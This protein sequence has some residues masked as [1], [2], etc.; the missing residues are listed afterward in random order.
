M[1]SG[2]NIISQAFR[3]VLSCW[4]YFFGIVLFLFILD[5]VNMLYDIDNSITVAKAFAEAGVVFYVCLSFLGLDVSSKENGKK[6]MGFSLRFLFLLYVPVIVAS[7][8][9]VALA[10]STLQ[11]AQPGTGYFMGLTMLCVGGVYFFAMFLFGTVFP[12]R[13]FGVRPEIGAAVGRAFRQAGY[14]IPRLLLGVWGLSALSFVILILAENLGIG[15]DPV[16]SAGVPN[17]AGAMV[18]VLVKLTSLFSLA[19]FAVIVCRAYLKDLRE[20]GEL[21]TRD[22]EV[23]A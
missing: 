13:L 5:C 9:V 15:S 6:Y 16:T 7:I 3:S 23:F 10:A 18:L 11:G 22:A 2:P 8:L 21:P 17:P 20:R 4:K 19:L 12:A 14:L 1:N